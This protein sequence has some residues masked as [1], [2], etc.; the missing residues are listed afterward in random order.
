MRLQELYEALAEVNALNYTEEEEGLMPWSELKDA[1]HWL[2]TK[3]IES[4]GFMSLSSFLLLL[5]SLLL[6]LYINPLV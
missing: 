4:S 1:L 2:F 6:F 5:L 3:V